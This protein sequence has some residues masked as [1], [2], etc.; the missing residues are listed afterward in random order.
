MLESA[1]LPVRTTNRV[2]LKRILDLLISTVG[3][4]TLIPIFALIASLIYWDSPGPIFYV[5]T[6]S[7]RQRRPFRIIKFRTMTTDADARLPEVL[8]YNL[9]RDPRLY[10]IPNDP[11]VTRVGAFLRRYSLDEL[12]QLLNVVRGEMSLVGPRPLMLMEDQH[13]TGKATMRA[14]V[15][16]GIT[17]LWQTSGRNDLTFEQ[18]MQL[19]C[20]YVERCSLPYDFWLLLRTVPV[21]FRHQ[22]AT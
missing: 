9:H 14:W 6:R 15:R 16:P 11:R 4:I 22:R 7:G 18:M 20:E 17:G 19:D 2:S 1:S 13:V 5:Q 12:P 8:A 10:K 21:I 3:V